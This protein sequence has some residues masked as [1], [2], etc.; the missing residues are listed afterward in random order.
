[1]IPKDLDAISKADIDTLVSNAVPER[2]TIEYKAQLPADLDD[3]K[4]E[5]LSDVS[6]FANAAGGDLIFGITDKRDSSGQPTGVAE[7]ADGLAGIN[8]GQQIGRL[9]NILRD[10]LDERIPGVR[11]KSLE[12]FPFGPIIIVRIPQSWSS[13]H[14][15]KFKNLSRFFSRTSA[16]RYQ[17]DVREIK[18]AVMAAETV[19][20][21]MASFR[22]E[23]I[24]KIVAGEPAAPLDPSPK[25]ILHLLPLQ[26]FS[27]KT[28]IDLA[29]VHTAENPKLLIPMGKSRQFGPPRYNFNGV[30]MSAGARDRP[31]TQSYVQLYRNG[32]L[33]AACAHFS[34]EDGKLLVAN[35]FENSILESIPRYL[36]IQ[37][38]LGVDPPVFVALSIVGAKGYKIMFSTQGGGFPCPGQIDSDVL[39]IQEEQIP[40]AHAELSFVLRHT[41]N[42]ISQ[43][44][45]WPGSLG[46]ANDGKRLQLPDVVQG[47]R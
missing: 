13:P 32:T 44:G 7:S 28:V 41:F 40:D 35:W 38:R 47:Q 21:K 30:I 4:R 42:T 2:R 34:E 45:G 15:V 10:G 16:G 43:A 12:G 46:Y 37:K 18:A 39:L 19:P 1:M 5:F 26:S 11:I 29:L 27:R 20:D 3:G 23:R 17:L 31:Q 8:A 25:F 9:E 22:A 36:E 6:S 33:E 14:M 24:S